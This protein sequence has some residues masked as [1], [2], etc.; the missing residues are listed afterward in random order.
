MA[1]L[2]GFFSLARGINTTK[3]QLDETQ[4]G[5][6]GPLQKEVE[7]KLSEEEL[8]TLKKKWELKWD[9]FSAELALRQDECERYWEGKQFSA[10]EHGTT[11]TSE[12]RPM[13]DNVIFESLETFLPVATKRNPEPQVSSDDTPEGEALADRVQKMLVY[14]ADRLRMKLKLKRLTRY[15]AIYF[16]GAIKVGWSEAENDISMSIV[17]TK[18]LI[19]DPEATID[20]GTYTGEYIGEIKRETASRLVKRFPKKTKEIEKH[21]DKKMGT[22]LAYTE[23][24]TNDL[25]FWTLKNEFL[26]KADNPHWNQPEE[27]V[28]IGETGEEQRL[29]KPGKN[30]FSQPRMPYIF[31]SVFNMGKHPHDDTSLVYQNLS[32]QDIINKRN[33]QIDR[34]ADN[35]NSG[36]AVSGDSFTQ[37]QASLAAESYRKGG[38]VWVPSGDVRSAIS[39]DAAPAMSSDIF[40]N[41]VDMRQRLLDIFGTRGTAPAGLLNEKTVRGK[42]INR[43]A[44]ESRIGG[45][46]SEYLEQVADLTFNWFVQLMYVYYDE[47]HYGSV[48]GATEG[49][50]AVMLSNLDLNRTLTISVKEGSLIPK[51]DVS[52]ANQAVDMA[53]AGKMSLVDLYETLEY[54]NALEMATRAWLELNAPHLLYGQ[55]PLVIQAV[56]EKQALEQ[57]KAQSQPQQ[58]GKQP[59]QPK[60]PQSPLAQ[61]PIPQ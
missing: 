54:P 52:R 48:L 55:D 14:H 58:K 24:W 17:R 45:G 7:F 11:Q 61:V 26:G 19:L 33:R 22:T 43:T 6:K 27:D 57:L 29:M 23:W 42:I 32:N 28:S 41:L 9:G 56:Q 49:K 15:W 12:R 10:V 31:L 18:R 1:L 51:D 39:R 47:T 36:L 3:S 2:D 37:E 40:T 25:V 53:S 44:D 21:V 20:E 38:V 13:V 34:N 4:E 16:L 60:Q 59:A 50:T 8:I 46:I 5:I 30:H 35:S